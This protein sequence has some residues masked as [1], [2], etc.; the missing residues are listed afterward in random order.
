MIRL[1]ALLPLLTLV[2]TGCPA[3]LKPETM[4]AQV[5]VT[6]H[7]S[8]SDD[9]IAVFGATDVS[10]RKPIHIMDKDFAQ[11]LHES[12]EKSGLFKRAATDARA[13]Y[14]LQTCCN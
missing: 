12:F 11:S 6:V 8:S 10:A 5:P 14:Q 4:I 9:V 2:C 1:G 7:K 3:T 13:T